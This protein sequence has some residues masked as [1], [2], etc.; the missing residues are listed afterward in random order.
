M[1]RRENI[2]RRMKEVPVSVRPENM[3]VI[4]QDEHRGE[5]NFYRRPPLG[6]E[7]DGLQM[8]EGSAG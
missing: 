4:E 3:I 7:R 2:E 5:L 8:D 6:P 1:Q